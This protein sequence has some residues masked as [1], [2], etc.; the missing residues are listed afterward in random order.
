MP[1]KRGFPV[2]LLLKKREI[3]TVVLLFIATLAMAQAAA[4]NGYICVFTTICY[5]ETGCSNDSPMTITIDEAERNRPLMSLP[6]TIVSTIKQI[7]EKPGIVSGTIS[8]VS[9]LAL[10]NVSLLTIYLNESARF[11]AHSFLSDAFSIEGRDRCE[12]N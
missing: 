3:T 2:C 5:E 12:A 8:Y 11:S 7:D 4:A 1:K 6:G 9:E 10:N